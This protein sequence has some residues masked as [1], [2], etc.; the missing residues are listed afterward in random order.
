V[1]VSRAA[2]GERKEGD[3]TVVRVKMGAQKVSGDGE[4]MTHQLE[5]RKELSIVAV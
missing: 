4:A 2:L 1:T 5:L 3:A